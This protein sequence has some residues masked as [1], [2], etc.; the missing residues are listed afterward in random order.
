MAK[1]DISLDTLDLEQGIN[2]E[3]LERAFDEQIGGAKPSRITEFV[4]TFK[5]SM[6]DKMKVQ[7]VART[8]LKNALPEGFARVFGVYDDLSRAADDIVSDIERKV[9]NDL[10]TLTKTAEQQLGRLKGKVSDPLYARIEANLKEKTIQYRDNKNALIDRSLVRKRNQQQQDEDTV[11]QAVDFNSTQ[12]QYQQIYSEKQNERR[13]NIDRTE[14]AMRDKIEQGRFKIE[15]KTWNTMNRALDRLVGYNEQVNYVYQQRSVEIQFRSYMK[16]RDILSIAEQQMEMHKAGYTALVRNTGLPEGRKIELEKVN[17]VS[18]ADYQKATSTLFGSG[19]SAL[20]TP[21]GKNSLP[22]FLATFSREVQRKISKPIIDAIQKSAGLTEGASLLDLIL[23]NKERAAGEAASSLADYLITD[24]G[25]PYLGKKVK[26]NI[27]RLLMAQGKGRHHQMNYLLDNVPAVMRDFVNSGPS[28]KFYIDAAK[29]ILAPH[30]PTFN[31]DDKL[32]GGY[33]N[34]SKPATFNQMTQR[35]IVEVIPGYLARMLNEIT[36]LRTGSDTAPLLTYDFTRG[37]FAGEHTAKSR[38]LKNV[39]SDKTSSAI[40]NSVAEVIRTIDPNGNLSGEARKVLAERLVADG[41]T[42]K[43]FNPEALIRK[44]SYSDADPAAVAEIIAAIKT[45]YEFSFSGRMKD[46]AD[47]FKKRQKASEKFLWMRDSIRV[48]NDEI[49]KIVSSGNTGFLRQAG[50]IKTDG[51]SDRIDYKRLWALMLSELPQYQEARNEWDEYQSG[52]PDDETFVGPLP[53][54]AIGKMFNKFMHKNKTS[55]SPEDYARSYANMRTNT[56]SVNQPKSNVDKKSDVAVDDTVKVSN[57]TKPFQINRSS[58]E[59]SLLDIQAESLKVQ[60]EILDLLRGKGADNNVS[61]NE[62]PSGPGPTKYQYVNN[63]IGRFI[64]NHDVKKDVLAERIFRTV[65][66]K[67]NISATDLF[68]GKYIDTK[69]RKLIFSMNDITGPV[70]DQSGQTVI[71][72]VDLQAG[73]K[74]NL[75]NIVKQV[76]GADSIISKALDLKHI[77]TEAV[78]SPEYRKNM[79]LYIPGN[80]KPVIYAKEMDQGHYFSAKTGEPIT[81]LEEVDGAILNADGNTVVTEEEIAEGLY[82]A[83]GEMIIDATGIRDNLGYK[84]S[85]KLASDLGKPFQSKLVK[86]YLGLAG[87]Y[88]NALGKGTTTQKIF[89]GM[90]LLAKAAYK[91]GKDIATM[92]VVHDAYLPG[93]TEP[94]LLVS[95]LRRGEYYK[96]RKDLHDSYPSSGPIRI[97][98]WEDVTATVYDSEGNVIIEGNDLKKLINADGTRHQIAKYTGVLGTIRRATLTNV[99]MFGQWLGRGYLKA[100]KNYYRWLGKK[101]SKIGGAFTKMLSRYVGEKPEELTAQSNIAQVSILEQIN[102]NLVD[103]MPNKNRP[104]S[105]QEKVADKAKEAAGKGIEKVQGKVGEKSA[106]GGLLGG[107]KDLLKNKESKEDDSENDIDIDIDG[108]DSDGKTSKRDRARNKKKAKGGKLGR[109]AKLAKLGK[110][111]GLGGSV[112]LMGRG[113]ASLG[114][115]LFNPYVLGGLAIAGGAYWLYDRYTSTT[116]DFLELRYLQYGIT[117]TST[118]LKVNKLEA[119][120]DKNTVRSENP[121]I[122]IPAASVTEILD[123]FGIDKDDKEDIIR[124]SRWFAGRF[125]PVF[126]KWISAMYRLKQNTPIQEID[127]KFNNGLKGDLLSLVKFPYSGE[128]PYLVNVN[129]MDS[130]DDL[131]NLVDKIKDR[132]DEL[133]KKYKASENDLGVAKSGDKPNNLQDKAKEAAKETAKATAVAGAVTDTNKTEMT[134]TQTIASKVNPVTLAKAPDKKL[135]EIQSIRM[136]AYGLGVL[137]SYQVIALLSLEDLMGRGLSVDVAGKDRSVNYRGDTEDLLIDAG[138]LFGY[139]L[140]NQDDARIQFVSWFY[141]RFIPAFYS[142]LNSAKATNFAQLNKL[143]STLKPEELVQVGNAIIGTVN[144][145]KESIW[146]IPSIFKING[147]LSDLKSFAENELKEL[148]AKVDAGVYETPTMKGS[149]QKSID[150]GTVKS[151]SFFAKVSEK[152]TAIKDSVVSTVKSGINAVGDFAGSVKDNVMYRVG[153]QGVQQSVGSTYTNVTEGN[154]GTWEKIPMP[155]QN[156]SAEAAKKT[157]EVVSQMV[158]IPVELLMIFCSIESGFD[159]LAKNSQ[160]SAT[161]WFQFIN[162]TWD[163]MLAKYGKKYGL[164]ADTPDRKLRLDPRINGLMGGEF[165]KENYITLKNALGRDPSDTDLYLAHFMGPGGAKKFLMSDQGKYAAQVFPEQ[166]GA[167]RSLFYTP[168]GQ[169]RTL[170]QLYTY[171]DGLVAKH[172]GRAG[173]ASTQEPG[174][175]VTDI[176]TEGINQ[177]SGAVPNGAVDN[178]PIS[179]S[180]T[181]AGTTAPSVS[182]TVSQTSGGITGSAPTTDIPQVA[183]GDTN[184]ASS[185]SSPAAGGIPNSGINEVVTPTPSSAPVSVPNTKPDNRLLEVQIEALKIQY[186]IRD[187]LKGLLDDKITELNKTSGQTTTQSSTPNAP[188]GKQPVPVSM[189]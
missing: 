19:L 156:K 24:V 174:K 9:P 175:V 10:L 115:A 77:Y 26:P 50:I 129:P 83:L 145:Q 126:S 84:V 183:G 189:A 87:D 134:K 86:G 121:E 92:G 56:S 128:T 45:Q 97:N 149:D 2:L 40:S 173:G 21:G 178:G 13:F 8:F 3:D 59:S 185:A 23:T 7:H 91:F 122:N 48:P 144:D 29:S 133:G 182:E 46:T 51:T 64:R 67:N 140:A 157:L 61:S 158:G 120:I 52:N 74:D 14:R 79:D 47:N 131:P 147:A 43:R 22:T 55:Y 171:F 53:K 103:L 68:S 188:A 44:F 164:P 155:A 5:D 89:R 39:V 36:M 125:K 27:D 41:A 104:G 167:N 81:S 33:K 94:I 20:G 106:L 30:I 141:N 160:S 88:Y 102:D 176:P 25:L 28:G 146:N 181:A 71:N 187:Y 108:A 15:T 137:D 31:L 180:Q 150:N 148:K 69:T 116:G 179:L 34:I 49:D 76:S 90:G 143:E 75:D 78:G 119:L 159:Y 65:N 114:A 153:A 73:L 163:A 80:V 166:A 186:Q 98:R 169:P 107:L 4:T 18:G 62:P 37:E 17:N 118:Q 117:D 136:R 95:K 132:F 32:E 93:Q 127:E 57:K 172:R 135:T 38:I 70:I 161:G 113:L 165:L 12:Q 168:T 154:G 142:Y 11:R 35:S 99:K 177:A 60:Y 42:G 1:K 130:K 6:K 82:N 124:F 139:N 96:I 54:S 105:W 123:A 170:G 109:L 63:G 111:A 100:S 162:S 138:K 58:Q 85:S 184:G 151:E 66:S 72:A 152:V 112:G 101:I 110:F 16:L